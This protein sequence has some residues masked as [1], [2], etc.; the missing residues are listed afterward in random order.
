MP[1]VTVVV[2][3]VRWCPHSPGVFV[4]IIWLRL[5]PVWISELTG[6]AGLPTEFR[7]RA[8]FQYN[9]DSYHLNINVA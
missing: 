2:P 4:L 9:G 3:A 5:S 7:Q 1:A 8:S 6:P